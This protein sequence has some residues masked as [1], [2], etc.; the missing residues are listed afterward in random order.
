MLFRSKTA[1]QFQTRIAVCINK[2]D[3]NPD[4]TEKIESFCRNN[5]LPLAG[6]IPFDPLAVKAVNQGLSIAEIECPSGT[7]VREVLDQTLMILQEPGKCG[8]D[9]VR[10]E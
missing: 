4:N 2:H 5:Q 10:I 7:A 6:R 8:P 3:T 1:Q 9:V